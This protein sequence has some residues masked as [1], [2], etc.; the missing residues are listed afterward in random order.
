MT[1]AAFLHG[2]DVT[3]LAE[4]PRPIQV[5]DMSVIGLIGTAPDAVAARKAWLLTPSN[6][7]KTWLRWE[8]ASVGAHGNDISVNLKVPAKANQALAVSVAGTRITVSLATG[9]TP[10]LSISRPNHVA[11]AITASTAASAL[12]V[13]TVE[14]GTLGLAITEDDDDNPVVAMTGEVVAT[15]DALDLTD[16]EQLA[17][18]DGVIGAAEDYEDGVW[19]AVEEDGE[20]LPTLGDPDYPAAILPTLGFKTLAEGRNAEMA[21]NTPRLYLARPS[22]DRIGDTG[23]IPAALDAIF[24]QGSARVV[25]VRVTEGVDDAATRV[26]LLG[27][28]SLDSGVH[29]F[30]LAQ[31]RV[32]VTPRILIAPGH[33]QV[34]AVAN[35]LIS[36]AERLRAV[37]VADCPDVAYSGAVRYRGNFGSDRLYLVWPQVYAYDHLSATNVATWASPRV[38]GVMARTDGELGFW[39]SPSN[40]EMLGVTNTA[41]AVPFTLGDPN[42]RANYLNEHAVATIVRDTGFRLWGNRSCSDDPRFAFLVMRRIFDAVHESVQAGLRWAVD[43]PIT[44]TFVESVLDSGNDFLADLIRKGAL[45]PGSRVYLDPDINS[46]DQLA[47]GRIYIN[48][49]AMGPPPAERITIRS[50]MD[51]DLLGSVTAPVSA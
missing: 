13:C 22:R 37:V 10:G 36:V 3:E 51:I 9:T 28:S 17:L 48:L 4:G 39:Y 18:A 25:V 16:A 12:V 21:L 14:T 50:A 35:E 30:G 8:A 23:T 5:A 27:D 6:K 15:G 33:S 44:R 1:E 26:N 29:A 41:R 43:R 46:P 34:K 49:E 31:E 42:C 11:A 2:I 38:A 19:E 45:L 20:T 40:K 47:Q 32:G 24:D 7:T